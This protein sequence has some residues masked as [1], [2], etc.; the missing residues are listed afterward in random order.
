M[1]RP[2]AWLAATARREKL[3]AMM[4]EMKKTDVSAKGRKGE[5]ETAGAA[6]E[7]QSL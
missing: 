7:A 2:R 6:G 5:L 4:I 1:A 3:R